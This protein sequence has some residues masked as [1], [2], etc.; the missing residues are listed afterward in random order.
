M[1]GTNIKPS[2]RKPSLSGSCIFIST[3]KIITRD[4]VMHIWDEEE[5]DDYGVKDGFFVVLKEKRVKAYYPVDT[6]KS[7]EERNN[8]KVV[9]K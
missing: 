6:I 4:M 7:V 5:Y 1:Y 3:L 9:Y 8:S 2:S